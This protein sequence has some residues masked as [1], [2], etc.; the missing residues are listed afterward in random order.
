MEEKT[1]RSCSKPR[2]QRS[3]PRRR[4]TNKR[5]EP[6][7]CLAAGGKPTLET[8]GFARAN[9]PDNIDLF[10]RQKSLV[11]IKDG[12]SNTIAFG[13]TTLD[14]AWISPGLGDYERPNN[15][16]KYSSG[17]ELGAQF[18]FCDGSVH[19]IDEAISP[20][21]FRA[22]CTIAGGEVIDDLTVKGK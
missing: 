15:G 4:F 2:K 1:W 13:E 7:L 21:V 19:F 17:H 14:H 6:F 22:L 3:I 9:Y 8:S 5:P 11:D 12:D 18:V 16:K 20:A 10:L